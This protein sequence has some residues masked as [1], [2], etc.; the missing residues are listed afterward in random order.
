MLTKNDMARLIAQ[1]LYSMP[2]LP[3]ADHR[4]VL[5]LCRFPKDTLTRQHAL[6]VKVLDQT[7][8]K[9]LP[10]DEVPGPEWTLTTGNIV[11]NVWERP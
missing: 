11:Q 3:A 10:V 5:Q 4:V 1:A 2:Q 6:A 9:V 8:R 7:R